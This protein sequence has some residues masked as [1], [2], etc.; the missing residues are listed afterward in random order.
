MYSL[1]RALFSSLMLLM[2]FLGS[3]A[4]SNADPV[5]IGGPIVNPEELQRQS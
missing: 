5:V 3:A 2:L 1:N 4:K